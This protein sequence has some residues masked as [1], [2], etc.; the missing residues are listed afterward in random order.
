MHSKINLVCCNTAHW[1]EGDATPRLCDDKSLIKIQ[2]KKGK[3][4]KV[5]D[6]K[7]KKR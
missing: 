3:L 4:Q 7:K 2:G 5:G 1:T 6:P